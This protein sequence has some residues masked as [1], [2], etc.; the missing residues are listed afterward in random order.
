M[1]KYRVNVSGCVCD[2]DTDFKCGFYIT[3]ENG[4]SVG[5]VGK[6]IQD[7]IDGMKGKGHPIEKPE[8]EK[9]EN[10]E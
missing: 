2:M 1:L 4:G 6:S 9:S 7:A 5:N 3:V 8:P 10:K